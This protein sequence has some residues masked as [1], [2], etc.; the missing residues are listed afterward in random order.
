MS[1][2]YEDIYKDVKAVS[3]ENKTL[4]VTVLPDYGSKLSSIVYKPS[5]YELLWQN[6][7]KNFIKNKYGDNYIMGEFSGFDEMFPCI[8][9]FFY[10]D[11]P[12]VG[13]EAPDHGEVWAV[14]W[15]YEIKDKSL[16][17]T[18]FGTRFPYQLFKNV[19]LFENGIIINYRVKNLSPFYFPYIWA[20][21]PLFN[22]V[23]GMEFIV[24][25]SMN[26][27]VNAVQSV[28]LG[29]YGRHYSFP[30]GVKEDGNEINFSIVPER[31]NFGYQK[32]FFLGKITAGWCFMYNPKE[33]LN[34]GFSYPSKKIPYLGMWLNEGGRAEQ[35]NIAPEPATGGMD[36]VDLSKKWNM[37]STLKPYEENSW[38]LYITVKEGEKVHK[39][40]EKG[41]FIM[42]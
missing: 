36:R 1:K 16:A 2:I 25:D 21:H 11:Y 35:Y 18:V 10:E 24:P 32:Y 28:T 5:G 27:I 20:A 37:S 13:V 8:D 17:M 39:M 34:I 30:M 26:K 31:N 7:S 23:E 15:S 33:Q 22:T 38:Y 40:D 42:R 29:D 6:P 9:R 3:L 41:N 12:W 4:K 19:E 14:P